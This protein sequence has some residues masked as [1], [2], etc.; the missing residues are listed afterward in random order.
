MK[1][2]QGPFT[3][4]WGSQRNGVY[5]STFPEVLGLGFYPSESEIFDQILV[6]QRGI[7]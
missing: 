4:L 2:E 1:S 7:S 5:G 3:Y 6:D